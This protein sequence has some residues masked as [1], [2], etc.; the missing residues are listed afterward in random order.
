MTCRVARS[1]QIH[2]QMEPVCCCECGT[3]NL[4]GF[5]TSRTLGPHVCPTCVQSMVECGARKEN[6]MRSSMR[7]Q[8]VA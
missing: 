5:H 1:F 6:G 4:E 2:P 8:P 7:G 3:A